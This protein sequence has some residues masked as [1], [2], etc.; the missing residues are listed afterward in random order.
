MIK[1]TPFLSTADTW[2][3]EFRVKLRGIKPGSMDEHG[4][5]L[6]RGH[7]QEYRLVRHSLVRIDVPVSTRRW[8][9]YLL[10]GWEPVE[11]LI[12]LTD[13]TA[14]GLLRR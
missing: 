10:H 4:N 11:W 13:C 9:T 12:D 8:A 1:I 5:I 14:T 7:F 2:N 3:G 6:C